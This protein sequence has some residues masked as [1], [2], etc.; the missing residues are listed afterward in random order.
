[1][2]VSSTQDE[3]PGYNQA[4]LPR[5]LVIF[6][7]KRSNTCKS[8]IQ[9]PGRLKTVDNLSKEEV[10]APW[11]VKTIISKEEEL[12]EILQQKH[13]KIAVISETKI[14]LHGTKDTRNYSTTQSG[15]K[16]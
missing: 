3:M 10:N 14:K 12:D 11:H 7:G 8:Q 5:E 6:Y 4:Y 2:T 9:Q 13:T 15:V 1:M 16:I